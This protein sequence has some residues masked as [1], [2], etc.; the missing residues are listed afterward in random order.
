MTIFDD[1]DR[2]HH[3]VIPVTCYYGICSTIGRTICN[4]TLRSSL[5]TRVYLRCAGIN[6][7]CGNTMVNL[8]ALDLAYCGLFKFNDNYLPKLQELDLSCNPL[9]LSTGNCL[10][11]LTDLTVQGNFSSGGRNYGGYPPIKDLGVSSLTYLDLSKCKLFEF[12][13]FSFPSL[14]GL[15]LYDTHLYRFSDN[16][17]PKLESLDVR[18]NPNLTS[19]G[20]DLPSLSF[21]Y[22]DD[23]G[24]EYIDCDLFLIQIPECHALPGSHESGVLTVLKDLPLPI[25]EDVSEYI[26]EI[27]TSS[28]RDYP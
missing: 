27:L 15:I 25:F 6:E 23:T 12:C 22:L 14:E 28:E 16:F 24:V 7:F 18:T 4:V 20:R 9:S 10:G 26:F 8:I 19:V 11:S 13:D 5:I 17:L 2:E 21:L 3:E 1:Y